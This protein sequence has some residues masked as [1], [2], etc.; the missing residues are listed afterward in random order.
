MKKLVYIIFAFVLITSVFT[1]LPIQ[2]APV[3]G[4]VIINYFWGDGCPHCAEAK[5]FLDQL[6]KSKPNLEIR[7]YEVWGSKENAKLLSEVGQY[8]NVN[9]GGVPFFVIGDKYV[10]GFGSAET[11]GKQIE[12]LVE[13]CEIKG[14]TDVMLQ[15]E[16]LNNN[17]PEPVEEDSKINEKLAQ[18]EV[19]LPLFGKVGLGSGAGKMSLF[20][21]TT[22]IGFLDGFNPCAMWVLLFL[23][24]LLLGMENKRRRWALGLAFIIASGLVYF[25][26]LAAWLNFFLFIGMIATIRIIV[27]L[28]AIA[29]GYFSLRSWWR[30][31]TGCIVEDSEKKKKV[32]VKLKKIVIKE[33]FWLALIGIILL[34]AAVNLIELMCSA[35]LPAIYTQVLALSELPTFTYYLYLMWYIFIFMLDDIIVFFIAMFTVQAFGISNRYSLY[36]KLIGGVII[37]ILGILLLFKPELLMFG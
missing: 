26:F 8:L 2:A 31:K 6:E 30:H 19:D 23:I 35:G 27:G 11:T 37:L 18:H 17:I 16:V 5:P 22:A 4:Q 34:A 13:M 32:F 29:S 1:S 25:L 14:C 7:R 10:V 28:V 21:L 3:A 20:G 36:V 24:S 9:V 33:N 12:Q 15:M